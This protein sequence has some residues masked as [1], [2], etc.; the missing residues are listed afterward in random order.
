MVK[1]FEPQKP[2]DED[3]EQFGKADG[4]SV[5][6]FV[7]FNADFT[8]NMVEAAKAAGEAVSGSFAEL[9]AKK[10]VANKL[11]RA[12]YHMLKDGTA[13]DVTRAFG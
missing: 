5:A 2:G 3:P 10:T 11:T 1:R 8:I 7:G 6:V 9:V 4:R 13:F 12:C